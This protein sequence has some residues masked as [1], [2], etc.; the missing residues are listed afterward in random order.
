M[1]V[2]LAAVIGLHE[3]GLVRILAVATGERVAALSDIPTLEEVGLKDFRSAS[4]NAI[5][6][7]PK[8]PAVVVDKL[9]GAVNEILRPPEVAAH[10]RKLH[11]MPVGGSPA[12]M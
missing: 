6:A 7:P 2:D 11:L 1:F 12:D 8:T 4:W 10:F 9:N 3:A 5:A